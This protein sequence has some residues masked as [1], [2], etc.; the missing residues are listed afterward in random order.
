MKARGEVRLYSPFNF[1]V[2][3]GGWLTPRFVRFTLGKGPNTHCT[4]GWV[5]IRTGLDG[6]GKYHPLGFDPRIAQ[7]VTSRY[8]EYAIPVHTTS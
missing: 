7:L 5:V 6:C 4:G 8:F 3:W 2:R 1:G